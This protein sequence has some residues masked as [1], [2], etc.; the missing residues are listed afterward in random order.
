LWIPGVGTVPP[1]FLRGFNYSGLTQL[2]FDLAGV[3][4]YTNLWVGESGF[5]Y[6][7]DLTTS[8]D[9]QFVDGGNVLWN[10]A[11]QLNVVPQD[12]SLFKVPSNAPNCPFQTVARDPLMTLA[13]LHSRK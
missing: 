13:I 3:P 8:S 6:W 10:F 11:P 5:Q 9:I 12:P 7:T 4:H 1:N 2:A